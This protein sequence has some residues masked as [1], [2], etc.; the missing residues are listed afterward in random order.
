MRSF[1]LALLFIALLGV[2]TQQPAQGDFTF[3]CPSCGPEMSCFGKEKSCVPQF[4][5]INCTDSLL[6]VPL[7]IDEKRLDGLCFYERNLLRTK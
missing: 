7:N 5:T 3:D 6:K 4:C 1:V 2:F